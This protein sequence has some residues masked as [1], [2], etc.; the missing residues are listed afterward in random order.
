MKFKIRSSASG[1][2]MTNARSKSETLS[3]TAKSY[4]QTW[5]KEQIYDRTKEFQ[6][7]YTE[8]G[9]LVE[10]EAINYFAESTGQ[11]MI[12][13]NES[14]FNNEYMTG[15][16]DLVLSDRIIDIKSSWDCFTFPLFDHTLDKN[17]FYQVQCYMD[18]TGKDFAQ[19]AY[20]L[21][22]T[23][24]EIIFREVNSL[25]WKLGMDEID[26]ELENTIRDRMTYKNVPAEKR[27]K[28]FDVEKDQG[29]I[30]SI[31]ERVDEC[32]NYIKSLL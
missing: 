8:K 7:K 13:K 28:I 15:S 25:M 12:L 1:Q 18:L 14:W 11:G 16:P 9:L 22:D 17:Y 21:M 29:V 20:V 3:Q 10:Q 23:P 2:I 19:V 27:I 24:E 31:Y 5:L 30:D 26:E 6:S 4:C 32:R